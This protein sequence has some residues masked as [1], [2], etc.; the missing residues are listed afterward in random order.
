MELNLVK[1]VCWGVGGDCW[2]FQISCWMG[3]HVVD[4][5]LENCHHPAGLIL[6]SKIT[7]VLADFLYQD[8]FCCAMG[9]RL[10][11]CK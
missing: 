11:L 3:I 8:I 6:G 7:E 9:R 10:G 5:K 4:D 1:S 2:L